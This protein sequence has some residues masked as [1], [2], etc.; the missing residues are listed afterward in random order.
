MSDFKYVIFFAVIII[1]IPIGIAIAKKNPSIE[2]FLWFLLLFFTA[3]T[4]DINFFSM[5]T[6]RGTSRGFE[7]G[8]VDITAIIIFFVIY[9]RRDKNPIEIPKGS[10][11]YLLYFLFSFIS[12]VNSEVYIYSFFEL[13]KMVRMY[14]Y[15]FVIYNLIRSFKDIEEFIKYMAIIVFFITFLVL[16]QKYIDGIFQTS[17]PFPHQNSL[18]MYLMLYGAIF[19]SYLLNRQNANLYFWTAAFGMCAI[20]IISTLS[21]GGM[22]VF[23]LCT[24]VIFL[25]SYSNKFSLKQFWITM[26]FIILGTG[27]LY[28]ASDT[29][30]ERVRT[31]PKES[32][33]VR[34][35]LAQAAQN[36]A[37]DKIAGVGLNNFAL[38][39]N[40]PY[41]YGEHIDRK[42]DEK[43]GLVE[44]VYLMVAAETGWHNLV[45]F[46][47]L[48]LY[49]YYINIKNYFALKVG[50][51]KK[52][53]YLAIAIMGALLGIYLQ[54]TMEWVLK[55][56]NNFY[57][58][59]FIFALIG[60]MHRLITQK[61]DKKPKT[62]S[63]SKSKKLK[64]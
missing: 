59:M 23:S 13:W 1:G 8:L 51:Y 40:P 10:F 3:K 29:I 50:R 47:L 64:T 35:V 38:K 36:M 12:I 22:A 16:K 26:L 54:S 42:E 53:R 17:G 57:Q 6:Y 34:V 41:T 49:F 43:G 37:N 45:V 4:E 27:V 48:L 31:A 19:L 24:L 30:M 55:Q 58:L 14:F 7:I 61:T 32:L 2:K 62:K 15:F 20:D 52:Y 63:K 56:T 46:A 25:L 21:R 5:E 44:T 18:V 60:A 28:K 39:I 33:D 9:S 11:L